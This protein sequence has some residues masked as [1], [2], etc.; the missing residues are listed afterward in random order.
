MQTAT[1]QLLKKGYR[2]HSIDLLR[3][4]VMIIMALDHTRDF[5]HSQAFTGNPLDL[6]TTTPL[7]FLTRWITH[8][9]A[10]IFVFLSGTSIYLQSL[11]KN[12][13]QLSIFLIK[14][15]L[16]L[17]LIELFV[18]SFAFTFD[19]GYSI[20]ILQTIWAI[21]ISMIILGFILWLPYAA[22]LTIGLAIVFGHNLLDFAEAKHMGGFGFGWSLLHHQNTFPIWGN[23][24]LMIFYPFLPWTGLMLVGYCTGKLFTNDINLNY[25]RKILLSLSIAVILFFIALRASN[26][27]GDP[28]QWTFKKNSFFTFLSFINTNKYPPSLLYMCMTIGPALLFLALFDSV[29]SR[30]ARIIIVYGRVPFLYYI[31]HFYILHLVCM[32]LFLMRGHTFNEGLN[33]TGSPFKFVNGGEGYNLGVVYFIWIIVV[34][35]LYPVCKWFSDYKQTHKK[36]WLSYL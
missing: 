8:F 15:G 11:R 16:W 24:N 35:A 1:A 5:F 31:L 18:M 3:G 2:I 26:I 4:L 21:G 36:W 29:R 20:F 28:F 30:L 12:K 13:K 7:L 10:P 25:R 23:H 34:A 9:C 33:V 19:V 32:I 27:Y 17:I 22:I 6:A 14:R